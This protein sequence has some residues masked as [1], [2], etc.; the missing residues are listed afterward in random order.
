M[1]RAS[2]GFLQNTRRIGSTLDILHFGRTLF[3]CKV[4]HIGYPLLASPATVLGHRG[5]ASRGDFAGDDN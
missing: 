3:E 1:L 4:L 2:G 5:D